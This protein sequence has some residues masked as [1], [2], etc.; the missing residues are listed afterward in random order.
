MWKIKYASKKEQGLKNIEKPENSQVKAILQQVSSTSGV[1]FEVL[2][3]IAN[4][5]SGLN[6]KAGNSTYKGLFALN[7]STA[8]QY[9]PALNYTNVFDPLINAEAGSKMLAA[10]KDYLAKDLSRKGLGSNLDFA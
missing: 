7:P 5:E 4:I 1:P 9:N 10:G 3:A 8:V 6:P 2:V